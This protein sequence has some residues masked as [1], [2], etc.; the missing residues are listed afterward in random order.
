MEKKLNKK[1]NFKQKPWIT[2]EIKNAI[3]KKNR[4]FKMYIKCVSS[5]KNILHQEYK[6]YRNSLSTLLKQR[7]KFYYNNYFRN[8][9]YNIKD[10][11]KGVKSIISSN[12]K[13]SGYPKI[14]INNKGEYLT[15]PNDIANQFNNFFC[16]IAPTLQSNIKPHF[17]S[18]HHYLT[19]PC[20]E[21][22]LTSPCTKK[23]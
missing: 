21:S 12:T 1:R 6:T 7:R 10:T 2:K 19:A 11:W 17:K 3:E 22:F 20:K 18:F 8:N 15:N 14:I 9:I 4:L 13:E 16:S 5:N 23:F